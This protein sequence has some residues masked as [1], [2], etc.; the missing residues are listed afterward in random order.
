MQLLKK[1]E[2]AWKSKDSSGKNLSKNKWGALFEGRQ[3]TYINFLQ[4]VTLN[5]NMNDLLHHSYL[6]LVSTFQNSKI[7]QSAR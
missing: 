3:P 5:V 2:P 1:K 7:S 6:F 4:S